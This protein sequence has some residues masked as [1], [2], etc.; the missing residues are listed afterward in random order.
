[1]N[2]FCDLFSFAVLCAANE[3][4]EKNLLSAYAD[5]RFLTAKNGNVRCL[6][7]PEEGSFS[8]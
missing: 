5:S 8:G 1:M 2:A 6:R 7:Q 3:C 4:D